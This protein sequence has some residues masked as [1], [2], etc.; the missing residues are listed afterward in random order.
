MSQMSAYEMG[1]P[2]HLYTLFTLSR[3]N[4]AVNASKNPSS[5]KNLILPNNIVSQVWYHN[6]YQMQASTEIKDITCMAREARHAR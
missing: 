3:L 6:E 1:R 2:T 4:G 5:V